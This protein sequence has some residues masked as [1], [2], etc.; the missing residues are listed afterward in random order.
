M[1]VREFLDEHGVAWRVCKLGANIKIQGEN[2][3]NLKK[4]QI[5]RSCARKLG[6]LKTRDGVEI[7]QIIHHQRIWNAIWALGTP[8]AKI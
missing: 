3:H 6:V 7:A 2:F 1:Q 4:Y 8:V 5:A